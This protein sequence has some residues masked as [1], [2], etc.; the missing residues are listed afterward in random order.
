MKL[1]LYLVFSCLL[2]S[3]SVVPA[4]EAAVANSGNVEAELISEVDAVVPGESFWIALRQD[5]RPGWHTYWRN[6][7]DSGAP[8]RLTFDLPA[9]FT[10]GDIEWPWPERIPYGPLVNF[11]YHGEVYFPV[12]ITAPPELEGEQVVL[13]ALGEWLVCEE[14]CIPEDAQLEL[15][16]PIKSAA[17]EINADIFNEVRQRIPEHIGL[18]SSYHVAGDRIVL[19]LELDGLVDNRLESVTY[20][21]YEVD[22]IDNAAQQSFKLTARGLD[23]ALK[24]GYDFA[25]AVSLDGIVV[26]TEN[27]GD[28]LTTAFAVAP[29]P[30]GRPAP[31]TPMIELSVEISL[32]TALLFAL[33]GGLIL[34]LMPCVF[35]VLSI[36]ILS[37]MQ[38]VGGDATYM[39]THGWVYAAGVVLCFVVIALVLILLRA[40]GAQIGWGFQLQSPLIV[41]LLAYLFVL[42]G[43]NFSGYF[44]FGTRLMNI[45]SAQAGRAGY[46]GSFATGIL[47][48][49]VA[50]PCTVPFMASAVGFALTRDN[51]T[52]IAIFVALGAG[53]AAPYVLLCYAPALLEKIPRPGPWMVR[54]REIL[55]FPMFASAIW[56]VWVLSQQ[57]GPEGVLITL[58]G[59]LMLAAAIWLWRHRPVRGVGSYL[60]VAVVI[61]LVGTALYLPS[62]LKRP[63][64]VMNGAGAETRPAMGANYDGP[65]WTSY[66]V[67]RLA[68]AR[69]SGP[70]FV[71]FTA[72]WCITCKVNEAVAL[73]SAVVRRAFESKQ[74]TY[75]KG[76]WTNED[77]VI[78]RALAEYQRSGVPL[79]LLYRPGRDRADVLP[80]VLTESI[81]LRAIESL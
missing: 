50:A 76:D 79:Y 63:I 40:G 44:E 80:Q 30:G 24:R 55:A 73:D 14:I 7:G 26:I 15:R 42:I 66:G 71:N 29:A 28:R 5:I 67:E 1:R 70:V 27:A 49:T 61:G 3:L 36:K 8:T 51:V 57:S 10:A 47:A 60:M 74:V 31:D 54:F 23:I 16:L 77:P 21:P 12:R 75:L 48:T 68:S 37:L 52:A 72:A 65:E 4:V 64:P 25:P 41:G 18:V 34:N 39:R 62:T 6:P 53:M 20:F 2:A 38:Q 17:Q 32:V 35:P 19:S 56:L 45:G 11:G 81:V 13:R 43:L 46:A 59:M 9:G 22:V 33:L 78:T 69:R 58:T